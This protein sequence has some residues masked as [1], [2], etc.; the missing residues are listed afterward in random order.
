ML[1]DILS[2]FVPKFGSKYAKEI[3]T[4]AYVTD[5]PWSKEKNKWCAAL[6]PI[7]RLYRRYQ[8][9]PSKVV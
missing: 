6:M 3:S 4:F 8:F 2:F 5:S 7:L 9:S 1:E